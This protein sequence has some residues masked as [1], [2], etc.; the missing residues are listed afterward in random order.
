M[1]RART[2]HLALALAALAGASCGGGDEAMPT[3][4]TVTGGTGLAAGVTVLYDRLGTPHVRASSD[5]DAAFALGYVQAR[6]RLWEMDL[7][8]R[9]A[10]G[11][12]AELLPPVAGSLGVQSDVFHRT[13]F[14][15]GRAHAL[16]GGGSSW[17]IEDAIVQGLRDRGRTDLLG[18]LQRFADGVNRYLEDA[19]AGRNGAALSPQYGLMGLAAADVAEWT[20][21]DTVAIGR[22]QTWNL[23]AGLEEELLAGQLAA[24]L[25]GNPATLPLF[26]DLTR[27]A[28]AD[29]SLILPPEAPALLA[30]PSPAPRLSAGAGASLAAGRAFVRGATALFATGERAGSNNWVIGPGRTASG[31]VLLANDPHLGLIMPATFQLV[32]LTTPTRDVTGVAFPGTPAVAIGHNG[33]VAWGQT[34]VGYDVTDLYL[35]EISGFPSGPFTARRGG[36]TVEVV[37]VPETIRVRTP[38]GFAEQTYVVLVV[39]GHG[40]VI[41]QTLS[42]TGATRTGVSMKWTGQIP[43]HEVLAL[44]DVN[45]AQTAAEAFAAWNDFGVGAQNTIFGD[46]QGAIAYYPHAL[47]PVRNL[48]PA[49]PPWLPLPSDGL[50]EWADR[51]IPDAEL[52]Q[53]APGSPPARGWVATAN[54]D[55]VGNVLDGDPLTND[56][57]YYLYAWPDVGY[58][59]GRVV[60]RIE[61]ALADGGTLSLDDMTSIQADDVSLLGRKVAPWAVALLGDRALSPAAAGARDLLAAWGTLGAHAWTTPTG[62][63]GTSASSGDA[64]SADERTASAAAAAFHA[65]YVQ[66][67][68]KVLNDELSPYGLTVDDVPGEQLGRILSALADGAGASPPLATTFYGQDL[69]DDVRTLQAETCADAVQN[70]VE[71]GAALVASRTGIADDPGAWRWGALHRVRFE[72]PLQA[73]FPFSPQLSVGPLPNDGGLYT[74]DVANLPVRPGTDFL[75]RSGAN[76]RMAVELAPG[77]VR[78]RAVLPGGN[79]ESPASRHASDQ[80]EAWLLN[81]PGDQPYAAADV[82]AAAVARITLGP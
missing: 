4:A 19:R 52:P 36:G 65:F 14:T 15:A 12:L 44:F 27:H 67:A 28:P 32:H 46:T 82:D 24:A 63:A 31:H 71:A 54:N 40:P 66:L 60:E 2:P 1:T 39:P 56:Y 51:F 26:L 25:A 29:P 77:A 80:I 61:A 11:R 64:S 38:T 81:Q 17:R 8:R 13:V 79:D 62:F 48:D 5:A 41:P 72:N 49:S 37:P 43:T 7:F 58:R 10:R 76:V 20:I 42:G 30:A 50:H 3:L 70:A 59:H 53:V 9:Q 6:A 57:P 16:D 23:S 69:C 78:W 33:K 35:E 55:I 73:L 45:G 34:V 74:V 47:V 18:F 22:L 68:G 21:E 75:Q